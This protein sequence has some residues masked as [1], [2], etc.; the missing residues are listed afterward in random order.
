MRGIV[1][2]LTS[3]AVV[4]SLS[5][6]LVAQQSTPIQPAPQPAVAAKPSVAPQAPAAVKVDLVLSRLN[7]TKTL[8]TLPYSLNAADSQRTS[9]RLGSQVPIP[10]GGANGPVQYQ[11]V[12]SN[13][14]CD[15][16]LLADGRYRLSLTIDDSSLADGAGTNL[17]PD[18]PPVIR[19]YRISTAL[20]LRGG[21]TTTFNVST[22]KVS[23]DTI[24]AQVTVTALK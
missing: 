10:V 20:V 6:I 5:G 15:V 17:S 18:A 14:D 1:P 13:I 4:V 19:S 24:R 8:S 21:E 9:L 11:N 22:D 7:G 12:G 16:A 2:A 23:G 3:A